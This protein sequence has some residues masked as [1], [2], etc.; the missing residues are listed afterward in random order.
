[1]ANTNTVGWD[2]RTVVEQAHKP[3]KRRDRYGVNHENTPKNEPG[4][5]FRDGTNDGVY[6]ARPSWRTTW[7]FPA[8]SGLPD[9]V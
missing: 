3:A 4:V 8:Y 6:T 9:I 7:A 1:M 2:S 5:L